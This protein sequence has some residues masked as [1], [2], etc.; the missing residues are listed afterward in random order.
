MLPQKWQRKCQRA[1]EN[2]NSNHPTELITT[3]IKAV[4]RSKARFPFLVKKPLEVDVL[5]NRPLGCL[6]FFF[7][8]F[9]SIL[10]GKSSR[11]GK[12]T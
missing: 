2:S 4:P 12:Q 3:G 10:K 1:E 11:L 8:F 7:F 9:S 6:V 5:K